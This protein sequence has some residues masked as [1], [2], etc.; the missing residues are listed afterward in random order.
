VNEAIIVEVRVKT[1]GSIRPLAFSWRGNQYRVSSIGRQWEQD[2][3]RHFLVM[4]PDERV[5]ELAYLHK[6][7]R[8]R[9]CRRPQDFRPPRRAV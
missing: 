7:G 4:T 2:D 8:W 9:L 6:E 1:D 5:Y 3:E